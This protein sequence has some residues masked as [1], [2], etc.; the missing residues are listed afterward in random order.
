MVQDGYFKHS[1]IVRI[2]TLDTKILRWEVLEKW[3]HF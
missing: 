1:Q 3:R 2:L